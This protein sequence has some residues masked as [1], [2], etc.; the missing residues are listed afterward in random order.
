GLGLYL[1][2]QWWRYESGQLR[3]AKRP[4]VIRRYLL[5]FERQRLATIDSPDVPYKWL[6]SSD[7]IPL[8]REVIQEQTSEAKVG[9]LEA[10]LLSSAGSLKLTFKP[11][12]QEP[13]TYV[14]PKDEGTNELRY[15]CDGPTKRR[16]P[17]N[18]LP[19]SP[20]AWLLG[21]RA[22]IRTYREN[23]DAKPFQ[24]L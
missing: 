7:A 17:K 3:P 5:S 2:G 9:V 13:L 6:S 18:Y 8:T 16:Y 15:L 14:Y 11:E 1:V 22:T 19:A 10:A 24:V 23:V 21:K 4:T 20:E 12:N